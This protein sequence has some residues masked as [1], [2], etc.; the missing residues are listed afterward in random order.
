MS[1]RKLRLLCELLSAVVI[2]LLFSLTVAGAEVQC[3]PE[4]GPAADFPVVQVPLYAFKELMESG[5]YRI[6]I[7]GQTG[8][9][10][11]LEI[12]A[13]NGQLVDL[14][15][16]TPR[17]IFFSGEGTF[18][19]TQEVD[20]EGRIIGGKSCYFLT[21]LSHTRKSKEERDS[22]A[23]AMD[24]REEIPKINHPDDFGVQSGT[25]NDIH[26]ASAKRHPKKLTFAQFGALS[27]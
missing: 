1:Q 3:P 13:S 23:Q 9:I 25:S 27:I 2:G 26:K 17:G 16:A 21:P 18:V 7:Q 19:V 10:H 22:S 5:T 11:I 4:D 12:S 14:T 24:R 6:G 20:L 15:V 8:I